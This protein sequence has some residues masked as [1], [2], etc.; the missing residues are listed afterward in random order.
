MG[1]TV[2]VNGH[3]INVYIEGDG[4]ETIVVLSGSGIASPILILKKYR[5]PYRN[6]IR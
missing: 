5:N 4:P 2:L 6:G 3:Q 1:K